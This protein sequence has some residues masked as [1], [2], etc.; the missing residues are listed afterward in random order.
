MDGTDTGGR[1]LVMFTSIHA[2]IY[3]AMHATIHLYIFAFHF[4]RRCPT[5]VGSHCRQS[6]EGIG[7]SGRG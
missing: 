2:A 6:M 5:G 3:V 1:T 4:P 7:H